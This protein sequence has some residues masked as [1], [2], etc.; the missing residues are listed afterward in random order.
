MKPGDLITAQETAKESIAQQK[1]ASTSYVNAQKNDA[2]IRAAQ[3]EA[4]TLSNNPRM[5]GPGSE[6]AQTLAKIKTFVTGKPPDSLV[7]LGTLNKVLLQ[8]G[9]QNVRQALEGQKITQAEFMKLLGEGNPN[10]QQPLQT[11]NKLLAYSAAQNDYDMR[12]NRTKQ[13]ALQRGAN[14]IGIDGAIAGMPGADRGDYVEGKVGVRPPA[15]G[16]QPSAGGGA[17]KITTQEAYDA[18]KNGDSYVDEN[19]KPHVK[20]GRK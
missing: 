18:L 14:P 15:A 3:R 13:I 10:T 4:A 5:A 1:A 17:P 12:F 11:I 8:M 16:A 7:D 19:G 20:G 6:V 2:L 9:A